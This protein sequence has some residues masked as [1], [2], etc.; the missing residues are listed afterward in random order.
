MC[1]WICDSSSKTGSGISHCTLNPYMACSSESQEGFC[2]SVDTT[3][4]ALNVARTCGTFGEACVSLDRYPN[5]TISDHG[6]ITGESAM[7]SEIFNRG[8]IACGIDAFKFL[9]YTS[10]IASGYSL[11]TDPVSS[12]TGFRT[13][14]GSVSRGCRTFST[15]STLLLPSLCRTLCSRCQSARLVSCLS[16]LTEC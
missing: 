7:T 12:D 13:L 14:T 2:P 4:S 5:A 10:G 8:P 16:V 9:D 1:Q 15:P 3:C 11:S 6:T